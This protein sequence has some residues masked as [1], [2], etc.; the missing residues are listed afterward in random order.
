MRSSLKMAMVRK[1]INKFMMHEFSYFL[2]IGYLWT[3]KTIE[4]HLRTT[5]V[6]SRC[7]NVYNAHMKEFR[8][9]DLKIWRFGVLMTFNWGYWGSSA[10]R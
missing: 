6:I 10:C 2:Y 4:S 3:M 7:L 8:K 9:C 5:H 1:S